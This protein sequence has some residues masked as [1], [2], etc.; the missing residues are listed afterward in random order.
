MTKT[1]LLLRQ[2]QQL[3]AKAA[4]TKNFDKLWQNVTGIKIQRRTMVRGN[5]QLNIF[6]LRKL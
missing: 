1:P 5:K 3:D 6:I 4:R 2:A